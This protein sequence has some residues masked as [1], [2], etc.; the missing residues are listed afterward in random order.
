MHYDVR[1][2]APDGYQTE[3]SY[4]AASPPESVG[5]IQLTVER[6]ADGEVSPYLHDVVAIGDQLEVRGPIGG[7]FVWDVAAGGPLMLIGGGSGIAPRSTPA[8][9]HGSSTAAAPPTM[10]SIEKSS[11]S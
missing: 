1:L 11:K 3:R 5:N 10:S 8:C 9:R 4:S 7:Y 2:T 6:I